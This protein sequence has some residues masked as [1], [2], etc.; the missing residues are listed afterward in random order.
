MAR[1]VVVGD[2]LAMGGRSYAASTLDVSFPGLVART[3]GLS[4]DQFRMPDFSPHGGLPFNLEWAARRLAAEHG[5]HISG[6]QWAA[7]ALRVADMLEE[8][9]HYWD[10]PPPQDDVLYHNIACWGMEV[11]NAFQVTSAFVGEEYRRRPKDVL[12]WPLLAILRIW[13]RVLNPA[14][15]PERKN[16]TMVDIAW[17][18]ADREGGIDHL[19]VSMGANNCTRAIIEMDLRETDLIEVPPLSGFT[20]WTAAAFAHEYRI[21]CSWLERVDARHVYLTTVPHM[22]VAP[23]ISGLMAEPASAIKGSYYDYYVRFEPRRLDPIWVP[24]ISG[25][26]MRLLDNRIDA[27]NA[28]IRHEAEKRGWAIIDLCALFDDLVSPDRRAARLPAELA[29]LTMDAFTIDT[30]GRL[31]SGGLMSLDGL[32]PTVCC[33]GLVAHLVLEAMRVHEPDVPAIDWA[34]VRAA[35]TLVSDPPPV[36]NDLTEMVR[37]LDDRINLSRLL[38]RWIRI[39]A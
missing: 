8:V 9:R 26:D 39:S 29:D 31:A 18:I 10:S 5:E 38:T 35:D 15:R 33:S 13:E 1:L 27:Y 12:H 28:A 11:G 4:A 6:F 23:I 2:S 36:L 14:D 34:A 19:V 21:L 32:H 22:S 17:R 7:V 24:H 37:V 30:E 3:L 20:V 25:D 16:D